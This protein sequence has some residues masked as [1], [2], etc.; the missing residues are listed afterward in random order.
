MTFLLKIYGAFY[1]HIYLVPSHNIRLNGY[2]WLKIGGNTLNEIINQ[3]KKLV[4]TFKILPY[5]FNKTQ[6]C[7]FSEL[8]KLVRGKGGV[9]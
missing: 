5:N 8:K 6:I 3:G 1:Y 7:K 4:L 9:L 2:D